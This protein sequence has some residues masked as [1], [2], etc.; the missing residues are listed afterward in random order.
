MKSKYYLQFNIAQTN[1]QTG[2]ESVRMTYMLNKKTAYAMELHAVLRILDMYKV[3]YDTRVADK[4]TIH[5]EISL[6]DFYRYKR[7][8]TTIMY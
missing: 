2:Q 3:S 4:N 6:T 5:V 7:F 1:Q 8:I